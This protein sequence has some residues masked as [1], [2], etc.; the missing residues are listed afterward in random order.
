MIDQLAPLGIDFVEQPT[1][2][3]DLPSLAAVRRAVSVPIC[4]NEVAWYP[5][6]WREVLRQE[7]ADV[8]CVNLA[9]CGGPTQVVQVANLAAAA[10]VRVVRHTIDIG[11]NDYAALHVLATLPNAM[12][13][14]QILAGH[15][16]EDVLEAGPLRPRGG[17]VPVPDTPGLGACVSEARVAA[18]H[19]RFVAEGNAKSSQ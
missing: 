12:D 16:E 8:L 7:A 6:E 19:Q 10:G 4:A 5:A 14:N 3:D 18:L 9:W 17:R 2:L 1:P 13:G 11:I 15:L